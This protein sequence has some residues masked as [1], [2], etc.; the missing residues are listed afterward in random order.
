ML[1]LSSKTI[2]RGLNIQAGLVIFIIFLFAFNKKD[3]NY[4]EMLKKK[5]PGYERHITGSFAQMWKPMAL[6]MVKEYKLNNGIAIDIGSSTSPFLIELAGVTEMRCYA[7]DINPWAMRL[8]GVFVDEAGLTGRVI[9]VEGDWQSMPFSDGY[10]DFIFSRGTIPFVDNKTKALR[11]TY[12]VLKPGGT[13]YIGHGG[14]GTLIDPKNRKI[15]VQQRLRWETPEGNKPSGWD[16][17]KEGLL[18][19][20]REAGIPEDSYRLITEPDIGWWLEIHK[21]VEKNHINGSFPP[22]ND[23]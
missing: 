16:G 4:I 7:L 14:F 6:Q 15:L 23:L 5:V 8:L 12:R 17:P 19:L 21:K 11:E 20:A 3:D 22:D 1:K 2:N 18:D 9:P 10:A 13:A